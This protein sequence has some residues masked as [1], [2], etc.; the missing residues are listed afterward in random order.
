VGDFVVNAR[1]LLD[2]AA[3]MD[4]KPFD[5]DTLRQ[6][7]VELGRRAHAEGK[8]V[9]ISVYGG[10][11]LM[12]TYDWRAA[13]RDVDEVF[14]ADRSTVRRLAA[15]I[16][17]ENG[18]DPDWLNDGVKGYL[19]VADQDAKTLAGTYPSEEE[20]GLRLMIPNAAY[21]FAMKC[22]A[23]RFGGLGQNSDIDDI[24]NLARELGIKDA[25]EALNLVAAFY[26]NSVLERKT[27]FGLE[28]ILGTIHRGGA[29]TTSGVNG[30]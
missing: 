15:A 8:T 27:Q 21:L 23:M 25:A 29:P 20:P 6:A 4:P 5:R 22:R 28:E 13:T 24:R 16:A 17:H 19:S 2:G 11:A 9:E 26:P 12:L 1:C 3:M 18:W 30:P 10:S 7:L 14:E